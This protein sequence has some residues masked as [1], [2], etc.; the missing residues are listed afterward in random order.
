MCVSSVTEFGAQRSALDRVAGNG[1]VWCAVLILANGVDLF[2][3]FDS[4]LV[5]GCVSVCVR[6]CDD[7]LG[8]VRVTPRTLRI[9]LAR[10]VYPHRHAIQSVHER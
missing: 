5:S 9:I 1:M 2:W 7:G 4:R 3:W 8:N 10:E 6:V